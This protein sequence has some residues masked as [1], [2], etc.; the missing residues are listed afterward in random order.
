MTTKLPNKPPISLVQ[1]AELRVRLVGMTPNAMARIV[2]M[3]DDGV[4]VGDT[5][6]S[7]WSPETWEKFKELAQSIENDYAAILCETTVVDQETGDYLDSPDEGIG[8]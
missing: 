6:F 4:Q 8:Y 5:V 7:A 2:F 1:L 3:R